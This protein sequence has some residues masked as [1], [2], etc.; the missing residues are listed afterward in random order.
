MS[1]RVFVPQDTTA[2]ALGAD[3]VAAELQAQITAASQDVTLVRNG[4]RGAF[5]L[6][7]LVEVECGQQRFLLGNM[8]PEDVSLLLAALAGETGTIEQRLQTHSRYLGSVDQVAYLALQHRVTFARSGLEDPLDLIAY[9]RLDGFAGLS[10]IDGVITGSYY[11][12]NVKEI[13]K[14]EKEELENVFIE[15]Q[16]KTL[17]ASWSLNLAADRLENMGWFGISV[18]KNSKNPE[19]ERVA[20]SASQF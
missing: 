11:G 7:P 20:S 14:Y 2:I 15:R 18:L 6:E 5:W 19:R 10:M 1:L 16:L 17:N 8:E 13:Y 3:Q 9:R 12:T 4:S